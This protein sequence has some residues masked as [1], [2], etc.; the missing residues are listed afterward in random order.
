MFQRHLD[1]L[2]T[3]LTDNGITPCRMFND[4]NLL[5][6]LACVPF[7]NLLYSM[8]LTTVNIHLSDEEMQFVD[9]ILKFRKIKNHKENFLL[10][11]PPRVLHYDSPILGRKENP[12]YEEEMEHYRVKLE[13]YEHRTQALEKQR[14]E[15]WQSPEAEIFNYVE[16]EYR[17]SVCSRCN[18]TGWSLPDEPDSDKDIT[19]D[20]N[21]SEEETMAAEIECPWCNGTGNSGYTPRVNPDQHQ[22]AEAF[23]VK[24]ENLK[25]PVFANFPLKKK[26]VFIR[27]T[28]DGQLFIK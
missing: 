23:R 5:N 11:T 18:G 17:T 15:L 7:N 19:K 24:L 12:R 20:R 26:P 6:Y 25:A 28:Y 10:D 4:T 2:K 14:E 22:I 1:E 13:E 3:F 27:L 16:K 8:K 21:K 9:F